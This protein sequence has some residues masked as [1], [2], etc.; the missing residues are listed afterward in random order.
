MASK[1]EKRQVSTLLPVFRRRHLIA[2]PHNADSWTVLGDCIL[3][4]RLHIVKKKGWSW[5]GEID[6]NAK[7]YQPG[8][9][10][11][12]NQKDE[13]DDFKVA[14]EELQPKDVAF[15][16]KEQEFSGLKYVDFADEEEEWAL[17]VLEE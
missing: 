16:A 6:L 7:S 15:F 14:T 2:Y 5:R 8:D 12:M 3:A 17:A 9:A 4:Y 10:G 13:V 1:V 11:F